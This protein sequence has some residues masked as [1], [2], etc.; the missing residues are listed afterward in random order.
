MSRQGVFRCLVSAAALV[1][2][3]SQGSAQSYSPSHKWSGLYVGFQTG[4]GWSKV[5]AVTGPYGGPYDQ[6]Y[7][8][9][10]NGFFAGPHIGYNW[11][12]GHYVW[13]LEADL[14][15]SNFST[16]STGTLG[17]IR[18][19]RVKWQ[20]TLRARVG[21]V[22]GPWLL[23]GTGGL[24]FSQVTSSSSL[25]GALSPFSSTGERHWGWT[26]GTGFERAVMQ[27]TTLRLEY[28]YLDFGKTSTSDAG[29]NVQS[30]SDISAH[31]LRAGI[32]FRF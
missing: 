15:A 16:Q 21:W 5:D 7:T 12:Y 32:S 23:Y 4:Y 9:W 28:R 27:N 6:S 17:Y 18:E 22:S 13:G 3:A 8:Y 26:I 31:Q 14:D 29:N 24:A 19:T 11:Q 30:E 25:A 1:A 10:S 20:S 2:C